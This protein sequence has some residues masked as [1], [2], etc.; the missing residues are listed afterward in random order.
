MPARQ[1]Y[2][3]GKYTSQCQFKGLRVLPDSPFISMLSAFDSHCTE[4]RKCAVFFAHTIFFLGEFSDN[5]GD[6]G[7]RP[8]SPINL[9][10]LG[11]AGLRQSSSPLSFTFQGFPKLSE[12]S[13]ENRS[14]LQIPRFFSCLVENSQNIS[15]GGNKISWRIVKGGECPGR[16][17]T[18]LGNR[19]SAGT[20]KLTCFFFASY[21]LF[22]TRPFTKSGSRAYFTHVP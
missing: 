12:N 2:P 15:S 20:N 17:N 3:S 21:V 19:A 7:T 14:S 16:G 1:T 11:S 18:E 5:F 13:P 10:L 6:C 22:F 9:M 4:L 8:S